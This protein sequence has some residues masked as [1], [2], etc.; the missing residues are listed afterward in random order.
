MAFNLATLFRRTSERNALY[1]LQRLDDH[2]LRDIGLTRTDVQKL[3]AGQR[4][5]HGRRVFGHE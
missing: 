4:T 3:M 5:A 2:L 1:D